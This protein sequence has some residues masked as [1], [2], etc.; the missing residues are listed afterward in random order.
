MEFGQP[1]APSPA[2]H[3]GAG[4]VGRRLAPFPRGFSRSPARPCVH[5]VP[6]LGMGGFG[7]YNCT[8][9]VSY[10][11]RSIPAWTCRAEIKYIPPATGTQRSCDF[12]LSFN[13]PCSAFLSLP[14]V[15]PFPS[16]PL[17]RALYCWLVRFYFCPAP[18]SPTPAWFLGDRASWSFGGRSE[19]ESALLS[20]LTTFLSLFYIE[21][22]NNIIPSLQDYG[23]GGIK[24]AVAQLIK[25]SKG[26]EFVS[27]ETRTE[28][29]AASPGAVGTSATFPPLGPRK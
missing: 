6:C 29:V 5:C 23:G 18:T 27:V 26:F 24:G 16:A 14:N 10:S 2:G 25:W 4:R 19:F 28:A 8:C 7:M 21:D 13:S 1:W 11:S 3:V 12:S 9:L 22:R 15:L 20:V 17:S